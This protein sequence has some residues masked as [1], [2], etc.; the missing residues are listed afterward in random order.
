V[1]DG[2]RGSAKARAREA[3]AAEVLLGAAEP[4]GPHLLVIGDLD[5]HVEAAWTREGHA[6]TRW[7]RT[8]VGDRPGRIWPGLGPYDACALRLPKEKLAFEMA[9]HASAGVLRPGAPLWVYGANDEGIKSSPQVLRPVFGPAVTVDARRHCRVV[10]A[11]CPEQPQARR[12]V[13]DWRRELAPPFP[14]PS[15]WVSY[16]GVFAR[17]GLDAGTAGL[18]E[19]LPEMAPQRVLDFGCGAGVI[20]AALQTRWPGA[21]LHALDTDAFAVQ[22]TRE[23]VPGI[24][25]HLSDAWHSA[26]EGRFDLIVS[27]PPLHRGKQTDHGPLQSLVTESP[28]RLTPGGVLVLVTQRQVPLDGLLAAHLATPEVLWQ[29]GAYRVWKAVAK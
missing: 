6:V 19:A 20:S 7:C 9:V 11:R 8:T 2:P 12:R 17:G 28:K 27:N 16:P 29:N 22:A 5:G 18:L 26:P 13:Q 25:V 23:N 15:R 21:E 1:N 24:T 14:G 3:I 10:E 4:P